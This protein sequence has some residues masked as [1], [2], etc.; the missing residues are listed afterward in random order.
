MGALFK[1]HPVPPIKKSLEIMGFTDKDASKKDEKIKDLEKRD[2]LLRDYERKSLLA[3]L[4][5][6]KDT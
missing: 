4:E 5:A 2:K 1:D 6:K 3:E